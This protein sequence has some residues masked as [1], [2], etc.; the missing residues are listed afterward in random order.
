M[1][2][3]GLL[4]ASTG[5]AQIIGADFDVHAAVDAGPSCDAAR[6]VEVLKDGLAYPWDIVTYDGHVYWTVEGATPNTGMV[7]GMP[8]TGGPVVTL[9]TGEN[10]PN[11]LLVTQDTVYWT[12]FV[13]GGG[14]RSV[15][16]AGGTAQT[17]VTEAMGALGIAADATNLYWTAGGVVKQRALVDGPGAGTAISRVYTTPGLLVGDGTYLY[18][19]DVVA[20][21]GV[22]RLDPTQPMTET[23]LATGQDNP[24]G[25]ALT[26]ST[27]TP[28]YLLFATFASPGAVYRSDKVAGGA[29]LIEGSLKSPATLAVSGND[30]YWTEFGGGNVARINWGT[31]GTVTTLASMQ[32]SPNGIALDDTYVYWTSYDTQGAVLRTTK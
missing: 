21:G 24:N 3:L 8:T 10:S 20:S 29:A 11:R 30:V 13:S 6:C 16:R 5:C 23:A 32:T 28:S 19:G 18:F 4:G 2:L 26:P 14:V 12:S 1:L 22:Y 25:V 17:F 15:P 31:P 27:V 7:M 9:A